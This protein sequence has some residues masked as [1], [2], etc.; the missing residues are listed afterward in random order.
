MASVTAGEARAA[1]AVPRQQTAADQVQVAL[2]SRREFLY[3]IWGA[4]IVLLLGEATAGLVWFALP[5][6]KEGTFGGVFSYPTDKVPEQA[7]K[8]V[9]VPEGRFHLS[10]AEDG[11]VALYGV[12]THLGCLP[13]WSDTNGR[14]ECPCHGSKFELAGQYIEGPAPRA[15]DR[16]RTTV[17]FADGTTAT[18]NDAGDPIPL[19]GRGEV[20]AIRIDTGD[21]IKRPG[22]L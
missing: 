15:L 4:S 2:P 11:L 5:I 1:A 18:T 9:S 13:K 14:F 6:F 3:Y 16:F 7:A 22:Y 10:Y 12:C 21:R 19:E 17:T 8:P 20:L